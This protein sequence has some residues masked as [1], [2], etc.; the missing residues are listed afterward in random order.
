M[1]R[2]NQLTAR[3]TM[4][5]RRTRRS[6]DGV[7]ASYVRELSAA[8]RRPAAARSRDHPSPSTRSATPCV[9]SGPSL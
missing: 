1:T 3:T 7:V 6:F 4:A 9:S 8:G 2:F 5:T